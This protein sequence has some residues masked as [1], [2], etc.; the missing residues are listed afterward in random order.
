[1]A[2][3]VVTDPWGK[4]WSSCA[5]RPGR[6]GSKSISALREGVRQLL[7]AAVHEVAEEHE[8]EHL[9]RAVPAVAEPRQVRDK[10]EQRDVA[11]V[12]RGADED[13]QVDPEAGEPRDR[14]LP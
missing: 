5:R 8:L 1:M 3:N 7:Q 9:V 4:R 10:V 14:V 13:Q 11:R 12:G 2:A 6:P